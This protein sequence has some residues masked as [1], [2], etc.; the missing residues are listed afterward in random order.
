MILTV[1]LPASA[2]YK[3]D[4]NSG[5]CVKRRPDFE[6]QEEVGEVSYIENSALLVFIKV[7]FIS[8]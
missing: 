3:S 2:V 7:W 4:I 6:G 1:K 8:S 5:N